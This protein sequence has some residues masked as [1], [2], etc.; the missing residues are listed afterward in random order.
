MHPAPRWSL[1]AAP[2]PRLAAVA[3]A[4]S[5]LLAAAALVPALVHLRDGA[6][7]GDWP[8]LAG[9]VEVLLGR[10][11]TAPL[12]L[13]A[14]S[15]AT[16]I[17]PLPLLVAAPLVLLPAPVGP[18]LLVALLALCLPACCA[19]L[20]GSARAALG[21]S[22]W[23]PCAT[24]AG[25]LFAAV[26][27]WRVAAEY[28]HPEDVL[29]AVALCAALRHLAHGRA[30]AA[31]VLL[32]LAASGKPWAVG[33]VPLAA[34]VPGGGAPRWR[35]AAA[36]ALVALLPWLPFL[37]G[38]P[39]T[40]GALGGFRV[41]VWHT[42]PLG[43]L[44]VP[45]GPV[46]GWVRPAQFAA[47]GLTC[48]LAVARGR[49]ELGAVGAIAARLAL[50]PQAWDYYFATLVVAA[51]AADV[52]RRRHRGPWLTIAAVVVLHDARWLAD[53][54]AVVAALQALPLVVV[55][56]LLVPGGSG[57]RAVAPC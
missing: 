45:A 46:P 56:A 3:R 18:A 31:A 43:L 48:A 21:D 27:W 11:G 35:C 33:L 23:V 54:V 39:D 28:A 38:S 13:Y 9:G 50:E 8:F 20:E 22:P 55:L 40:L 49:W 19:L 2:P 26:Y 36:A 41:D 44:G 51:L 57:R 29:V 7:P 34:A 12:D 6:L 25:G 10:S 1:P 16:Q 4:R 30:G 17:G 14:A 42:S 24:L 15:P 5:V 53:G 37:L 52:L 47:A 32:G